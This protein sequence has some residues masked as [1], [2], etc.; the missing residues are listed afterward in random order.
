[1]DIVI[2]APDYGDSQNGALYIVLGAAVPDNPVNVAESAN[3][4]FVQGNSPYDQLGEDVILADT[5][6]NGT[7]EIYS[8]FA[9][10]KTLRLDLA[11]STSSEGEETTEEDEEGTNSASDS[12]SLVSSPDSHNTSLFIIL[13]C[14]LIIAIRRTVILRPM[15]DNTGSS[16]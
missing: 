15:D 9:Q 7:P 3:V 10:T 6:G 4:L 5:D 16:L 11:G 12:C 1:M 8:V 14:V 2:G 13:S